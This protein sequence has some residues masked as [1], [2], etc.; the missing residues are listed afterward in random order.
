MEDVVGCFAGRDYALGDAALQLSQFTLT[1][2]ASLLSHNSQRHAD[3]QRPRP[4]TESGV[5]GQRESSHSNPVGEGSPDGGPVRLLVSRPDGITG[6]YNKRQR[7][8]C[9]LLFDILP[10][11][12]LALR[13]S[14]W[15]LQ[16]LENRPFG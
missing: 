3:I 6:K 2:L 5:K 13:S 12:H 1:S 16:V 8:E 15:T 14:C 11:D 7:P 10:R 9:R 4:Q